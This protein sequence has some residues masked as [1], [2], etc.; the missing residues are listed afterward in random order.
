MDKTEYR[1][2]SVL[3]WENA[4]RTYLAVALLLLALATILVITDFNNAVGP[5]DALVWKAVGIAMDDSNQYH[6]P[7]EIA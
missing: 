7:H 5:V 2:L 1:K 3:A 4:A 6:V